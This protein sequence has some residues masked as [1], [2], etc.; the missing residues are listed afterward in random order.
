M[1]ECILPSLPF[2]TGRYD[3]S[4]AEMSLTQRL[5]Y[6]AACMEADVTSRSI[7]AITPSPFRVRERPGVFGLSA[8][9]NHNEQQLE[10]ERECYT[11]IYHMVR[12]LDKC[13]NATGFDEWYSVNSLLMRQLAYITIQFMIGYK[14]MEHFRATIELVWLRFESPGRFLAATTSRQVVTFIG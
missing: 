3:N 13:I 4:D 1:R 7:F 14:R 9:L 10:E 2:V 12:F 8:K 5:F 11:E 6:V